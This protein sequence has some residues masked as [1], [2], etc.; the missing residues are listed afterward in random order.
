MGFRESMLDGA[1]QR[2]LEASRAH[3]PVA[4]VVDL[5]EQRASDGSL[6][7]PAFYRD[8]GEVYYRE[9]TGSQDQKVG[10][11]LMDG[12]ITDSLALE[13]AIRL[14]DDRGRRH[15]RDSDAKEL[16]EWGARVLADIKRQLEV[17]PPVTVDEA[18]NSSSASGDTGSGGDSK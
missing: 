7:F 1:R 17:E 8:F 6:I 13:L 4:V 12:Q 5:P 2:I 10:K 15:F 9:L 18:G 3:G 11:L 14:C 16:A